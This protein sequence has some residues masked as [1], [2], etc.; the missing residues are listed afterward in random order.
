[1]KGFYISLL[2]ELKNGKKILGCDHSDYI[3]LLFFNFIFCIK[4][5]FR[6]CPILVMEF[7]STIIAL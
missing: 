6:F 2:L 1:M 3:C 4:G 7:S 5:Y